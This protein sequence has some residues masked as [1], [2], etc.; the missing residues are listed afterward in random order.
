MMRLSPAGVYT[1]VDDGASTGTLC[2][3]RCG[4]HRYDMWLMMWR[5]TVHYLV[6]DVASNDTLCGGLRS[7]PGYLKWRSPILEK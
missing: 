5:A 1:V 6:D 7:F 3:G 2:G 4:E